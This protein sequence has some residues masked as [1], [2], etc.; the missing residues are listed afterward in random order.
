MPEDIHVEDEPAVELARFRTDVLNALRAPQGQR[1]ISPK[2]LY[3]AR[4]SELFEQITDLEEYYPT[5]TE[6]ELLEREVGD[7]AKTLGPGVRLVEPGSGAGI[8]VQRLLA[9]LESPTGVVPV[10]ISE[11][12]LVASA[13]ILLDK[14]PELDVHGVRAD[15]TRPFELPD[16]PQGTERTVVFF[17]G[18]TIGNFEE[19]TAVRLLESFRKIV[20]HRGGILVGVDLKKPVEVLVPAYDDASGVTAAFNKNLLRRMRTE[21]GAELDE[22]GWRHVARYEEKPSRM[23]IELQAIGPQSIEIG[24]EVFRFPDG[25]TIRTEYSHKPSIED[26]SSLVVDAGLRVEK[27]WTDP[28]GWFGQFWLVVDEK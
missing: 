14:F 8:K 20:G 23:V 4:G 1:S 11:E 19:A 5:R 13:E 3:D 24:G 26:F 2:W 15:F 25:D 17:P 28:K 7:I 6:L 12:P 18:S 22:D 27:V 10:E 21:L 9:A 16:P